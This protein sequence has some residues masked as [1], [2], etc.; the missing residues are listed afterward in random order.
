MLRYW[1]VRTAGEWALGSRFVNEF[2]IVIRRCFSGTGMQQ[3]G[4]NGAGTAYPVHRQM[5]VESKPLLPRCWSGG[6]LVPPWTHPGTIAS[7]SKG[8]PLSCCE[9]PH[10]SHPSI[11]NRILSHH[12]RLNDLVQSHLGGGDQ[13]M[14]YRARG[15]ADRATC[16]TGAAPVAVRCWSGGGPM[17][18][19]QMPDIKALAGIAFWLWVTS[20]T[21]CLDGA[22][23]AQPRRRPGESPMWIAQT[24]GIEGFARLTCA[25]GEAQI[26]FSVVGPFTIWFAGFASPS[27]RTLY[28]NPRS[29]RLA[30]TVARSDHLHPPGA[31][32]EP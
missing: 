12:F 23:T 29:L 8:A 19:A 5:A 27:A 16:F 32:R 24:I 25:A 13:V 22:G 20:S 9:T 7:R 18:I 26:T 11:V 10:P 2:G 6:G 31:H 3:T 28:W 14:A 21:P 15:H 4:R 1:A 17:W 30:R